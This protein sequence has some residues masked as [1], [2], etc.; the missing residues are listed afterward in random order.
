MRLRVL[1]KR[2]PDGKITLQE[3]AKIAIVTINRPA[4]RNALTT[5]MW[6]KLRA[7]GEEIASNEKIKVVIM[8]GIPGSFTAGSDI[9]EFAEMSLEEV[10][11]AFELMEKTISI[12]EDLSVPVI[13]AIDGP[14]LG[15][16]FVLSL[17]CDIRV[18]T[19]RTAMGM[20]VSKLGI[21]LSPSFVHRISR[22][23]GPSRTKELIMTNDIYNY[24][25]AYKTG[26]LNRLTSSS[27]L[28]KSVLSL[29][30]YLRLQSRASMKAVKQSLR[31]TD[32]SDQHP[33]NYVDAVDF[34]EGC[35]AFLEKRAPR[36]N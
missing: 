21:T 24:R 2:A 25:K 36:F 6:K 29:S 32:W 13:G 11:E 19:P 23:I 12:F 20:P 1:I 17:A 15:A 31:L 34:R 10:N 16:G 4:K 9:G 5:T 22:M 3:T 14:A 35:R 26:L 33:W 18:G 8:R 30:N 7:I 27:E 28:T